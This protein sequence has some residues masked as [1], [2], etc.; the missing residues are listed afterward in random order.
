MVVHEKWAADPGVLAKWAEGR[1]PEPD[2]EGFVDGCL[3]S[4]ATRS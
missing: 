3:S 2:L 1:R 4:M